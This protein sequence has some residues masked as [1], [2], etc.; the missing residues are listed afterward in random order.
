[1][2]TASIAKGI[3]PARLRNARKMRCF[4]FREL[5]EATG[6]SISPTALEKYEKGKMF[7]SS[8]V[9][10]KLARALNVN[11]DDF[12]RPF[13]V[14][15]DLNNVKYRKEASLGKKKQAAIN[16]YA[17]NELEKYLEVENMCGESCCFSANFH[18]VEVR[19]ENDA[20][21]VAARFRECFNLGKSPIS[22]PIELLESSGVKIIEIKVEKKFDADS[23]TVDGMFVIILNKNLSEERKR[24]TLFHEVGHKVMNF[25]DGVDEERL[26][27]IFA[28]EVLLPTD[29][30]VQKIGKIRKDISLVE[31]KDMQGQYGISVDAMMIK[32]RQAGI[33]SKKRYE[34]F[35]KH[36]NA[37]KSFK[38]DVEKS[39]FPAEHCQRYERMVF[40]LFANEEITASK[41][42]SLLG[43]TVTEVRDQLNLV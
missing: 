33:I 37:V 5:S 12:F 26:C 28:N 8:N 30:F 19:T 14:E 31:L 13:T 40:K 42:A 24:L 3:F 1:M 25:A 11:I 41:C 36:K 38:D 20:R 32:A 34:S 21:S 16:N 43:S 39:I 7:P 9:V 17:A 6:N 15:I 27:H 22:K 35:C 29:V 2:E 23:F 10:I 4:S 18:D